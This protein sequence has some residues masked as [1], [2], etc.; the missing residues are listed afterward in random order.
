MA[1]EDY[2]YARTDFRGYMDMSLPLGSTYKDIDMQKF[3]NISFFVF[4]YKKTKI[5]FYDVKY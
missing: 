5:I 1:L 4:L 3:L 2:P